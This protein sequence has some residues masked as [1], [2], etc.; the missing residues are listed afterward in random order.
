[1]NTIKIDYLLII[2]CRR[3]SSRVKFKNRKK[4]K[5]RTLYEL[6]IEQARKIS[7]KK[8]K[9]VVNTDDE[10]IL[11]YCHR[12]N[13]D[14]YKRK[15]KH[16]QTN[17]NVSETIIDMIQNKY[18]EKTYDIKNIIILQTTSPLRKLLDI[19][20]AINIFENGKYKSLCSL[21]ETNVNIN[22]INRL[23]KKQTLENFLPKK[24]LF[25]NSQ[26]LPKSY[27]VNGAIFIS[28]LNEYIKFKR[29]F[30]RPKSVAYVMP[31]SRS[32][33][34]DTEFDYKICKSLI[35]MNLND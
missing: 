33:D 27:A 21:S 14:Y 2:P 3:N 16:A 23:N 10:E 17:S 8:I 31:A 32:I 34:I 12:T 30:N 6:A 19:R 28:D 13:I 15:K 25:K 11:N 22:W 4:I 1:M 26:D 35:E 9:L 29:F 5:N 18:N 7:N 24:Y 20:N